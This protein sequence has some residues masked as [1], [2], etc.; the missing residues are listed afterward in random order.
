MV[1][2]YLTNHEVCK[3]QQSEK[4]FRDQ[5]NFVGGITFASI[6]YDQ[7]CESIVAALEFDDRDS[8]KLAIPSDAYLLNENGKT[9]EKVRI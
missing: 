7:S 9:I 3:G 5:W 2:K 6:Y 1:L 8:M 4:V